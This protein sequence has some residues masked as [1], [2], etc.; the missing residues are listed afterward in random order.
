ML[1]RV[2]Q[3]YTRA[4]YISDAVI[5]IMGITLALIGGS[6]LV[7][8]TATWFR[9]ASLITAMTIYAVTLVAM[10]VC[11]A[12]YNMIT[13]PS[14]NDVLRRID[15]SAIYLKIAGTYTPFIALTGASAGWFL[16]AIWG[17]ALSGA[18]MIIFARGRVRMAS[19]I[20]YLAIGWAGLIAGAEFM[21]DLS[22]AGLVLVIIGGSLYTA[23]V[24]FLL[25]ERLPFHNTIWHVFVL[26][27]TAVLYAALIVELVKRASVAMGVPG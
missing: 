13:R 8:L 24:G 6:I 2:T 9:D 16:A 1:A 5:H 17:L 14:W 15:Q 10:L 26:A 27:A 22:T 12:L 3:E 20:L 21:G 18:S 19:I 11:S 4:E 25:W 23:G 7:T